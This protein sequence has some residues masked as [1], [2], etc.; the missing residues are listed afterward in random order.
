MANM[1]LA[2]AT[3]NS[4]AQRFQVLLDAGAGNGTIKIYTGTQPASAD[5]GIGGATLLGTL[6]FSKPSAPASSGGVLTFNAITQDDAADATGTATW[7]RIV[8]STGNTI[9][10]CDVGT[11]GATIN[12]NTTSIVA[13]GPI[14]ITSFTITVPAS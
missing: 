14:A 11:A 4:L 1:R 13:G 12:L 2:A 5:D 3:R 9:F 7:A 6:T 10:D 8:D